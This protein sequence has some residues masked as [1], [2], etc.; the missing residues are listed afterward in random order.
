MDDY[1]FVSAPMAGRQFSVFGSNF[2]ENSAAGGGALAC[3]NIKLVKFASGG[4]LHFVNNVAQGA[5]GAVLLHNTVLIFTSD[6][7]NDVS[8]FTGNRVIISSTPIDL[9]LTGGGAVALSFASTTFYSC[10]FSHNVVQDAG[11]CLAVDA[12]ASS[13]IPCS[14]GGAIASLNS[15][16]SLWNEGGPK[17]IRFQQNSGLL[18]GAH[19]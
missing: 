11:V 9:P 8:T 2:S 12:S 19:N 17:I 18:L 15:Q 5:G 4:N 10:T 3:V 6:N 16:L 1:L 14:C 7:G 13:S